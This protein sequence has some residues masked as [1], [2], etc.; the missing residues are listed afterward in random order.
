MK[1]TKTKESMGSFSMN[2]GI[3]WRR[4]PAWIK[5]TRYVVGFQSPHVYNVG[6]LSSNYVWYVNHFAPETCKPRKVVRASNLHMNYA[7]PHKITPHHIKSCSTVPCLP[8]QPRQVWIVAIFCF[9]SILQGRESYSFVVLFF[10]SLLFNLI[11][12][13]TVSYGLYRLMGRWAG[14]SFWPEYFILVSW[15]DS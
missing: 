6:I 4:G 9:K 2:L 7:E 13:S 8:Y 12:C 15:I 5:A 10:G 1:Q 3:S 11:W 14:H